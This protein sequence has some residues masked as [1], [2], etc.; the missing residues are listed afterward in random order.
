MAPGEAPGVIK[1]VRD[2]DAAG[3]L[4]TLGKTVAPM[5]GCGETVRA[6]A[7]P[8]VWWNS[9]QGCAVIGYPGYSREY[10]WVNTSSG[11]ICTNGRGYTASGVAGWYSTSC[12]GGAHLVPWGNTLAYTQ[13]RGMSLSGG[14]GTYDWHS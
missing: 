5:A 13:M 11:Y 7:G 14:I 3:K 10:N 9:V 6:V 8:G 2:A 4:Q 12:S 1:A